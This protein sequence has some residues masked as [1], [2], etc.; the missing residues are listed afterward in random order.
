MKNYQTVKRII[1]LGPSA[2]ATA[3]AAGVVDALGADYVTIEL[4]VGTAINTNAGAVVVK[5]QESDTNVASNF[6]DI[7]TTLLQASVPLSTTGGQVAAFHVNM[8]GT[9]KR[10]LRLFATPGTVA[11]NSAVLLTAIANI[12]LGIRPAGT[13]GQADVVAIG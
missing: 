10:F 1:A 7:N 3:T 2:A 11:S 13:V 4:A 5:I 9:R 12:E 8:N 6:A